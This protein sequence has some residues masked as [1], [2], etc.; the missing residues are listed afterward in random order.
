MTNKT[1]RAH[2]IGICGVGMSATAKLLKDLGWEITGSDSGFYP[3]ISDYLEDHKINIVQGYNKENIPKD[4]DV[5]VIGK[6]AKLVP[7]TNEEVKAALDSG[8]SVRSFPEILEGLI[9]ESKNIVVAGSYGKSTAS[10]LMA[11]CLE[12]SGKN[13]GYFTGAVPIGMKENAKLGDGKIFILEGDEYPSSNWDDSPKFLY[14]N[15]HD[16]LLTSAKHDHIN[17][18]P[19]IKEYHI[20]FTTL[21]SILPENGITVV[22]AD[23]EEALNLAKKSSDRIVTYGVDN[24]ADWM[25]KNIKYGETTTFT[26]QKKGVDVI[27]IST[28][29]LGK[30]NIQ[31]ILG[32]CALLLERQLITP[33]EL[34]KIIPTFKGLKRRLDLK[35]YKSIIPIYEGFGSS[36]EKVRSGIEA[37]KTHFPNKRLVIVFEPHTFSWRNKNT[38]HW[39]DTVFEGAEKVLVFEP[40]SQGAGTHD[41]LTQK[42]IIDRIGKT[43][44]DVEPIQTEEETLNLLEK[45]LDKDDVILLSTSGDLGGMIEPIT[46]LVEKLYPKK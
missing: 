44:L 12:E 15:P 38:I 45:T 4:A 9:S 10:A 29:L 16:V 3:P 23:E 21:L 22:S 35:T 20:P 25:A 5:I 2:F 42:E 28:T 11:W 43:G 46:K 6:N 34:K 31:N 33:E 41:Q 13:P 30:H 32:V 26:L 39:Y 37:M 1:K 36:Y 17:V 40:A 19:T 18:Y 27:D 7:E 8:I 14:Y 24:D